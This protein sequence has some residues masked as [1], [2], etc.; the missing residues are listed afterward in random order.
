MT[1]VTTRK[2]AWNNDNES[3]NDNDVNHGFEIVHDALVYTLHD[4]TE[5]PN[6]WLIFVSQLTIDVFSDGTI[7]TNI[8]DL[9]ILNPAMQYPN[10]TVTRER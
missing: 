7:L 2:K 8:C 10:L 4:Q 6:S 1:R 5:I 9:K 3:D